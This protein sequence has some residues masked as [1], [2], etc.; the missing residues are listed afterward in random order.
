MDGRRPVRHHHLRWRRGIFLEALG[1]EQESR[2]SFEQAQQ[3]IDEPVDFYIG[4]AQ[5]YLRTNQVDKA[6]ADIRI[7][8][9]SDDTIA[10]AWLMLGQAL[11]VQDKRGEAIMAYQQASD[12]AVEQGDN[13]VVVLARLALGR[14]SAAP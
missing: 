4:R 5:Y 9:D 13:E 6:E 12:L 2:D 1:R 14:I 7:A 10:R 8:L 11:E 3:V